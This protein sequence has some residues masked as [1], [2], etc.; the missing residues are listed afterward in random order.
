MRNTALALVLLAAAC[1]NGGGTND[2]GKKDAADPPMVDSPPPI[3]APALIGCTPRNGTTVSVRQ[4]GRVSGGAMLATSPP[5]DGRLFVLEQGGRIRI[6]ENEMLNPTPFL[7]ISGVT[8]FV[9]GGEQGLLGL[10][11]H[12]NY[13]NN[14]Q[15]YVYYTTGNANIVA[16]YTQSTTNPNVADTTGEILLSIPDFA[17]NHNGGMIEFGSDG[18][19]Y[20]GT[21]DGG[22]GGDPQRTGQNA[23]NLLGKI[24]RIDV[25]NP[26]GGKPYGIPA[27]NPFATSGGAPEVFILGLRNPWRWS[28]DR[29]TGDMWIG[30]VGQG[31]DEEMTVLKAPITPG[32]NLGWS[33]FEADRCYGNYTPCT[34]G[35]HA[36]NNMV[37]P[38][39]I[40]PQGQGWRAI[41]GGQVYR[42][43][44]FPDLVGTY[45]FTDNA[46][47]PL[48]T[49]KLEANGTVTT[50]NLPGTWPAGPASIHADA[51]GELYL[52][53]TQGFVWQ[54]EAGP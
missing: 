9:G 27:D 36:G 30:D 39:V 16:K 50:A 18:F 51:R 19:L 29:A 54:I 40:R 4:I 41:I 20:I 24:L 13:G 35:D 49:G 38:Q 45:F 25:N 23:N 31:A 17:S 42:G 7:D 48:Q 52:T 37:G 28:F 2:G 32:T 22:G 21:G 44:C 10:A 43:T 11:F 33:K 46:L 47:R 15:F 1:G 53:T 12:P 6:F 14:R 34:N 5:N 8:G 26:A 3:D